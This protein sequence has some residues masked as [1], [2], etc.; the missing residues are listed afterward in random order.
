MAHHWRA[1]I[2]SEYT[3]ADIGADAATRSERQ[4]SNV[5]NLATD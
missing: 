2:G 1:W 5:R 4:K 3:V